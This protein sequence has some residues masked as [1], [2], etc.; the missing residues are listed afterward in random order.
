MKRS[1]LID[2]FL[3]DGEE[4]RCGRVVV[5]GRGECVGPLSI[6][7]ARQKIARPSHIVRRNAVAVEL[8]MPAV[9]AEFDA[10]VVNALDEPQAAKQVGIVALRIEASGLAEGGSEIADARTGVARVTICTICSAARAGP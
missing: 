7:Q 6:R 10:P 1:S 8:L 4:A 5:P 2:T 3:D 9:I